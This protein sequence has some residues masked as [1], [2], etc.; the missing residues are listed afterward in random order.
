MKNCINIVG[1]VLAFECLTLLSFSQATDDPETLFRY[2]PESAK[3]GVLWMWMGSNISKDGITK[4]LEV[5]KKQGFNRT[6]MFSLA[7]ITTPWAGEIKNSPTPEIIA[8]TEPWWRMVRHA[9]EESKRL[10]MDFGM[11]NGA[12]YE[13]SGGA[14]ITPELSMQELCWSETPVNGN[15]Q[16]ALYLKQPVVNLRGHTP[17]PVYNPETG[18]VEIPEIPARATYYKD[19]AVLA[20][21]A[22]GVVSKSQVLNLSDKMQADGKINWTAPPGDW[23]IYRFGHTTSGTLVQP[24]QWSATGLECDKMSQRAID[25][26]MDYMIAAV[27]K[28]LGDLIGSGFTHLHFD[29]YEAGTPTWTPKMPE[30]FLKRRGYSLIAQLPVFAGRTIDSKND[31][32]QFRNDFD[33]TLKD[34]YR[35]IYFTTIAKKLAAANLRFLCEP[36]GG[37][38]RQD[39]IM[40]KIGTVMTEFWTN[41]GQFTPYELYATVASLRKSGQNIIEAEAFTGMPGDSKWDETPA[42]IKPIGD[43]A[44]CAG[45]NR[46]V[47]HRFVHQPWTDK[48]QPGA[49]F[50]QWGTHFDRTQTWWAPGKAMIEYWQRCQ[51][52]LQWGN[53]VPSANDDFTSLSTD[54]LQ[55]KFIHRKNKDTDIYFLANSANI[56]GAAVCTF[57][58]SGKQPELWD[59]VTGEIKSLYQFTVEKNKIVFRIPFAA[60]QSYFVIFRK[61]AVAKVTKATADFAGTKTIKLLAGPWQ[62]SFD[63]IWGGP[64]KPV[65][66]DTLLD[67]TKHISS[68]IKYYSGTAVY[69]KRFDFSEQ[70]RL[71][72]SMG[73]D[74]N[75]GL[76]KH[77]ARVKL[78]GKDLGVVWTAPWRIKIPPGLLKISN[79][80]LE[81]AITNVWANRLIGDEQEPSDAE[82]LPGHMGDVLP[83]YD[84]GQF[85]KAFPNWFL[86]NKPRPAKGRYCFTT[87]NY[88]TNASPLVSSGLLG[89]VRLTKEDYNEN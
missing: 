47:L 85:L 40:P 30:E 79:N 34:L 15:D 81:I 2:P 43:A 13:S 14:W 50:G 53:I 55:L 19:I 86:Q 52:L 67:W 80:Q 36:Y 87:W 70:A 41:N 61:P 51:A 11:Y 38:W 56:G 9:A 3:P 26:H 84:N 31:S 17:F 59:P 33:A 63:S 71:S 46:L 1:L 78:N 75:L 44:F 60:A 74:L 27:K 45:V 76:V 39:E 58:V 83:G 21:P 4:D 12:G 65:F 5:L 24:A 42:S 69:K 7:D 37:P 82:W 22:K 54:S 16:P 89:P 35:D 49:S 73:I 57:D 48:Y 32:T 20:M 6:T 18:K 28:N 23:I 62:V 68:G 29:S 77:I 25:F 8:W 64:A 66:F 10:G 72:N 88:F